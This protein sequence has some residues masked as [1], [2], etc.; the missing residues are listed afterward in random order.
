MASCSLMAPL[1]PG[2][3]GA[4]DL[5]CRGIGGLPRATA[6]SLPSVAA[7]R[8]APVLGLI[9]YGC[10]CKTSASGMWPPRGA[11]WQRKTST[12][13]AAGGHAGAIDEISLGAAPDIESEPKFELSHCATKGIGAYATSAI[14]RGERILQDRPLVCWEEPDGDNCD[15]QASS[16]AW[17]A[18]DRDLFAILRTKDAAV[19][20]TFWDLADAFSEPG[21]DKTAVGIL[22]TNGV[23]A[24]RTA[25]VYPR[26]ARFNHSCR[27]NVHHARQSSTAVEV[28]H[29]TR[30]I[31]AGEELCIS[32]LFPP[33][34]VRADRQQRLRQRWGF[35]CACEVCSLQGD[36]HRRSDELR[37]RLAA[38]DYKMRAYSDLARGRGVSPTDAQAAE[39]AVFRLVEELTS[40]LQEE[41]AGNPA[42]LAS[43]LVE[44]NE[45]LS[46]VGRPQAAAAVLEMAE[47]ASILASG[48]DSELT[49][50]IQRR[51]NACQSF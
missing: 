22:Y 13:C 51:G 36:D 37:R 41:L 6:A 24:G 38:L 11:A 5:Q 32:Y 27:P 21:H 49:L 43:A 35:T 28:M 34:R 16:E 39:G 30:N 1:L 7:M 42:P 8:C 2:S 3:P 12:R 19:Q 45:V 47:R 20:A 33:Y 31:E 29:A 25:R 50:M 44:A 26:L 23:Q 17:A 48:T 15:L 46:A 14:R 9:A 40:G 18:C 10:R 4:T